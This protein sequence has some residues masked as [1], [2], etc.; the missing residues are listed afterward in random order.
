MHVLDLI[1]Q[2]LL[3][4]LGALATLAWLAG[5]I[6][7]AHRSRRERAGAGLFAAALMLSLLSATVPIVAGTAALIARFQSIAQT[8]SGGV[9][10]VTEMCL[11]VCRSGLYG[12]VVTAACLLITAA[13]A[14]RTAGGDMAPDV[15][16]AA[17]TI[18][19]RSRLGAAAM[20]L[21]VAAAA[22]MMWLH[23]DMVQAAAAAVLPL[24]NRPPA[25]LGTAAWMSMLERDAPLLLFGGSMVTLF[26]T[27]DGVAAFLKN[28]PP[29]RH[30]AFAAT[31]LLLIVA[32]AVWWAVRLAAVVALL[33]GIT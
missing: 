5:P 31:G 21:S 9:R 18:A 24:G 16:A 12:A 33:N 10:T 26:L 32:A 22:V 28:G 7:L 2:A 23:D 3:S 30:R 15:S 13:F 11:V 1:P 29:L 8:G 4:G 6:A 27:L 25:G 19:T 20:A 17:P 14:F